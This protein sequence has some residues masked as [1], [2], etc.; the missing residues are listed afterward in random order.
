MWKEC[1]GSSLKADKPSENSQCF[2]VES[3]STSF[4]NSSGVR[5]YPY[6]SKNKAQVMI[7]YSSST[8]N[9]IWTRP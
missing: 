6:I 4:S 9:R 3:K 1:T 8:E 5:W 2:K 7:C